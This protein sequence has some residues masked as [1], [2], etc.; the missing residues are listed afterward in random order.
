MIAVWQ[1]WK[2]ASQGKAKMVF[3][4]PPCRWSGFT[5]WLCF[6]ALFFF[7]T[8]PEICIIGRKYCKRSLV[9]STS[10]PEC[11]IIVPK[12]LLACMTWLS[13]VSCFSR[14]TCI[15]KRGLRTPVP[16]H[17]HCPG[18]DS[19]LNY[20]TKWCVCGCSGW[21]NSGSVFP[22]GCK[23][24]GG[25]KNQHFRSLPNLSDLNMRNVPC[26]DVHKGILET[27]RGAKQFRNVFLSLQMAWKSMWDG[28][29][30]DLLSSV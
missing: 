22:G 13:V 18:T 8:V 28:N 26:C 1:L 5:T 24:W 2:N 27:T 11:K 10:L 20:F 3:H 30:L 15:C 23:G 16:Y 7:F 14:N 21:R 19:S 25:K 29:C 12:C 17:E 4:Q 6:D 9:G